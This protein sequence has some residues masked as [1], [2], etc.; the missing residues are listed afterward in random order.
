GIPD[1]FI[2]PVS[3]PL[4][5]LVARYAR[6]HGPF[7]TTDIGERFALGVAVVAVTLDRLSITG[8]VTRGEF[9]PGSAGTEWCDTGVLRLI[10]RRSMAKLRKEIEP[11]PGDALGRFLPAWQHSQRWF[12]A[13]G[14][15]RGTDGV[16]RVVEQLQG[17]VLP[18]SALEQ[19][20]L[21]ARVVD[22]QPNMLDELTTSGEVLW[23]GHGSL[24]GNDGWISLYLADNAPML[25]PAREPANESTGSDSAAGGLAEQVVAA[26]SGGGALFF[27]ELSARVNSTDDRA[28]ADAIWQLVWDNL[29]TNDS[30][31][32]LRVLLGSGRPRH[33]Q[34]TASKRGR[35]VLPSRTGPPAVGGRWSLLPL[36]SGDA[37]RRSHALAEV[38][39][40]RYGIVTRGAVQA[41]GTAGGFAAV[42]R[43]LTAFEEAGRCRRGYFVEGLGAAQFAL[44]GAVDRLR[45]LAGADREDSPRALVLAATDPANPYGAALPWPVKPAA[46]DREGSIRE[47]VGH[48]PGR[49]AGALVVL[50]DGALVLYV[51][52]GGKTLLSFEPEATLDAGASAS[53][54]ID[55]AVDALALAVRDGWLGR[56]DLERADGA[57]VFTSPLAVALEAAGFRATP[58]GLRW[59]SS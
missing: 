28:L 31:A 57:S 42:Y 23:A 39:L 54:R 36:P 52:R 12:A 32:P 37:T 14:P 10:R 16:L 33:R 47:P 41:E 24:P 58:R 38:L 53:S 15:L 29:L 43:V 20:V 22:Y 5:D 13:G 55:A 26:L 17:A 48:R 45:G 6:T 25:L 35:P 51:E 46:G 30:V 40:D 21:P 8:R 18:A 3:D 7:V 50:V 34:G 11:V 49:K 4:G 44:P 9:R 2:E 27:R 56:L 19:L 59:R 1:A